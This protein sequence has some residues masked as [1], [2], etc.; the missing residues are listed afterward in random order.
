MKTVMNL[1]IYSKEMQNFIRETNARRKRSGTLDYDTCQSV[2]ECAAEAKSDA[3]FGI[4]YYYFAEYYMQE[5]NPDQTMH[6]LAECAKCFKNA[7]LFEYLPR[8]YNMMG[9]VSEFTGNR[10]IAL[11][12]YYSC[13]QYAEIY[14]DTYAHAM[15]DSNLAYI[16][17]RMKH[18]TEAKEHYERSIFYFEGSEETIFSVR[19][20]VECLIFGGFCHLLLGEK[21]EALANQRQ[22]RG[23]LAKEPGCR[24]SKLGLAAFEAGC[25]MLKGNSKDARELMRYVE[26]G[27]YREEDLTEVQAVIV[28]I[29]D[30]LNSMNDDRRLE[31]L[32]Q[33]LDERQI[34]ENPT[35]YFDLYPYK[36]KYLLKKDRIEEYIDYTKQYFALYQR[37]L[38][39]GKR[40]T[41]RM[42][43]LQDKLSRVELE[44]K[45]IR[46]YNRK[47]E[48]IALY[49]SMT[50][51][52]NRSHLNEYLSQK[53]EEACEKQI[54]LGVELMDI[55]HFKAYNDTYGHLEGDVCIEAVAS[56]L[57]GVQN[58]RVFCA[59]YGGDEFMIVYSEMSIKEIQ[60]VAETIQRNVRALEMQHEGAGFG[61]KVTV[62][63]GIFVR[64]PD[65]ENREWDFNSMADSV[66]YGAKREGRNR[67][68]IVTEFD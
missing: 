61:A 62:T 27:V 12:Y 45:D 3:I 59:R 57:K 41:A 20:V 18:Y 14:R 24:H 34:E 40:L 19:N 65:E 50:G 42:L 47:L 58:E 66:L 17:L 28:I 31:S 23:L 22:V 33:L 15:A 52:A 4:G 43:K 8:V 11:S 35:V 44:Q 56:V 26:E 7:D 13:L 2:L 51:L 48:S 46:A 32:I 38:E 49:D 5:E 53:F 36:S 39:D 54:L 9:V 64:V 63:Q 55:D 25:E 60:L 68:R 21:E 6:C 10:L 30:L 29:A 37:R 16:L 1:S 67:Y